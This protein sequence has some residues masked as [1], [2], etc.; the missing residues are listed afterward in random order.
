MLPFVGLENLV[1]VKAGPKLST[2]I[3]VWLMLV[4]TI[5]Q[6]MVRSEK[7]VESFPVSHRELVI[8][9][10]NDRTVFVVLES[11]LLVKNIVHNLDIIYRPAAATRPLC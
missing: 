8:F 1:V 5:P 7:D 3:R 4:I 6:E 9:K 2:I 10:P 11:T